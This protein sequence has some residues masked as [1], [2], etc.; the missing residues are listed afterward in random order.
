MAVSSRGLRV[1]AKSAKGH[2][3]VV[4]GF[5]NLNTFLSLNQ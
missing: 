1:K 5:E 3:I 4:V 2:G